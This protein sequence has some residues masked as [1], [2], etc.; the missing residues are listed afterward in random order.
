MTDMSKTGIEPVASAVGGEPSRK[1]AL[2]SFFTIQ[3]SKNY[4]YFF[5]CSSSAYC[6]RALMEVPAKTQDSCGE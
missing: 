6:K 5:I 2:N 3:T 4:I 1:E